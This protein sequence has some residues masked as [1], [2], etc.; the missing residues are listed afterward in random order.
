MKKISTHLVL[1]YI[2][3]QNVCTYAFQQLPSGFPQAEREKINI[4]TNWDFYLERCVAT[5][6]KMQPPPVQYR[7]VDADWEKV[8]L[9]H[10]LEL[11]SND[12][13][14]S[15]DDPFQLTF[16][17]HIGWYS[18]TFKIEADADQKIFLEFEG[19]HQ[20][21][22]LWVN[23]QHV[24]EHSIGGYTPFHF[25]ITD[26]VKKNSTNTITVSAD[27]R[28]HKHIP[29]DG[30]QFDFIKFGGLYRD[31]YLVKTNSLHITF[32]WE[33]SNAGV[34]I[35]TPSVTLEN[36]TLTVKT[37]VIN[38]A[39]T[40]QQCQVRTRIIDKTG[41]VV[42]KME[43]SKTI[44]AGENFTFSQTG[45][46]TENLH[47][48]SPESPYLYRVNTVIL[49]NNKIVDIQENNLGIR[50]YEFIKGAGFF[51]NGKN[52]ELIGANRHQAYP[53][54]GDA[55]PNSLQWKDAYQFKQAGFNMIRLAHYPH[56]NAFVEACDELG[57]LLYEEP[58]SWIGIGDE[59]WFDNL[60]E[61]TR[62]MIR[63]HK[64]HPSILMWGGSLNHR[65]P[66]EQLHYAVKEED[67][68]RPSA[69]NGSPWT[70]PRGSGICDIYTPMDY[71]NMPIYDDEISY[72]CEHGGS[73]DASRNQYE[74]SRSR[75]SKNRI[76]VA[77]WTA[78]DYHSFKS[79]RAMNPRRTWSW[80]RVPNEPFYWYQSELLPQPIVHI[81]DER[82]SKD[83]KV[84]VF[85]NCQEVILKH[86]GKQVAR[87]YPD[88]NPATAY[89]HH[90]SFTFDLD[91]KTEKIE[92]I[93]LMNGV[94]IQNH[95]LQKNTQPT[96]LKLE[97][98]M[99]ERPFNANGFSIKTVRAYVL[100]TNGNVV[101]N[102]KSMVS[103]EVE[104]Q[105]ALI[106]KNLKDANP[107]EAYYGVA[108]AMV[109]STSERGKIKITASA[110][111]LQSDTLTFQ[112]QKISSNDVIVA[113]AKPIFDNK[114]EKID[115]GG[116][117]QF[118]QFGWRAWNGSANAKKNVGDG[119]G[120]VID[121]SNEQQVRASKG[122]N[123]FSL[124]SFEGVTL[125]ISSEQNLEWT[126]SWGQSGP[127]AYLNM[128]GVKVSADQ[129][130]V[131]TIKGLKKGKYG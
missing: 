102:D 16:Q 2:L 30:D 76:G 37:N 114:V 63:N 91:W 86:N 25:D 115:I 107:N 94:A 45:G 9:P 60:E 27:N 56:D 129:R 126:T 80:Y 53:F 23:G 99:D 117:E 32:P 98:E 14:G 100:D 95:F 109:R 29:P 35:T 61:A 113:S 69:S 33:R 131:L 111:N 106:G 36:A 51:L 112:T 119:N 83:G 8:N 26:F 40:P 70:G 66:V 105:G 62:R 128:D 12:M 5:D 127:L 77:V 96:R 11:F 116:Q 34:S 13:N 88:V 46:I 24:G 3:L 41:N 85:S 71:Q 110:K 87:Q 121:I 97:I 31:V 120:N 54:I 67:P 10:G 104:G 6:D 48:W 92:A 42:L 47:L 22:N 93:G 4:N 38:E 108:T 59:K 1:T 123:I 49:A 44:N 39:S 57:I 18:R 101:R 90:P 50:W 15:T 28:K 75:A 103:F 55:V 118:L 20:V 78:H 68:T 72:L 84:I 58:P 65:G 17:R 52:V 7:S 89:V 74:L 64:N 79:N 130:L 81:G 124:K 43:K 82:I 125:E 73:A 122:E 19:A 21:T